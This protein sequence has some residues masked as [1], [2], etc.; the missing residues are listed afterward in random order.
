MNAIAFLKKTTVIELSLY[1]LASPI[2]IFLLGWC[3]SVIGIPLCFLLI[4]ELYAFR[5][6]LKL[7]PE[8]RMCRNSKDIHNCLIVCFAIAIVLLFCGVGGFVFQTWDYEKHNL[9]YYALLT[10]SF[11]VEIAA[12][13]QLV[14]CLAYYLPSVFLTKVV[15]G[16]I[17][18]LNIFSYLY[19]YLGIILLVFNVFAYIKSWSI[20]PMLLLFDGLDIIP[21]LIRTAVPIHQFWPL[22]SEKWMSFYGAEWASNIQYS[23]MGSGLWWVPQHAL[24]AWI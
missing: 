10:R 1:Y 9:I 24:V 22:W 4:Y 11:P 5:R 15:C 6:S 3:K 2:V 12:D 7:L 8:S 17:L 19:A 16:N 13:K 14:Y 18:V 21:A 20:L 23:S